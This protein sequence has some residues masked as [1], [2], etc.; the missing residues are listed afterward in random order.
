MRFL[1]QSLYATTS[2]PHPL[3]RVSVLIGVDTSDVFWQQNRAA[4]EA[5]ART[6][7]ALDLQVVSYPPARGDFLAFNALMQDAFKRNADY[8]VRVN[9]DTEFKT[10]GWIPLGVA[11]LLAFQ[12]PNVGVVGPTCH[13]GNTVILTHDMVHRTHLHIFDKYYPAVFHN[14]Y[15]D[16]WISTVYGPARTTKLS[17][18]VVHHHVELGTRYTPAQLDSRVLGSAVAAGVATIQA[19]VQHGAAQKMQI[20]VLGKDRAASLRRLLVSLEETDYA[21]DAVDVHIHIDHSSANAES[22]AVARAFVFSWGNVTCSVSSSARGLRGAWVQ[23]W[24]PAVGERAVI[25]EDDIQLSP[26]W[27]VWLKEAW[28]SYGHRPDLAG[29]SLQRQ[30]LVPQTPH[31]QREVVNEHVPFLYALV[32]SIGFSP[33]WRHWRAFVT[34]MASVDAETVNVQTPGLVTSEWFDRLDRRQV[35]TQY[36]IWYCREHGLYTLYVNLPDRKTL[37]AHMREKGQHYSGHDGRDFDVATGVRL[38]FPAQL[39]RY[40]W[41]GMPVLGRVPGKASMPR[42]RHVPETS[43]S[44]LREALATRV[45]RDITPVCRGM[46]APLSAGAFLFVMMA[47]R[48]FVPLIQN[49]ICNTGLMPGVHERTLIIFTDA[50]DED[51]AVSGF[52]GKVARVRTLPPEFESDMDY[53][54]YGYWRLVQLRVQLTLELVR[55]GVPF[56][57]CEPDALWVSNP[58]LDTALSSNED[59]I[60]FDDGGV[61]GFGWVRVMPT[62]SVRAIFTELER[63]FSARMQLGAGLAAH[64]PMQ[65]SDCEQGILRELVQHAT[66]TSNGTFGFKMLSAT[67]YVNGMWYDGGRGG[68]GVQKRAACRA[69]GAGCVCMCA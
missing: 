56:L 53:D 62:G 37:A 23:A 27:Y 46:L 34:W 35:W 18:W 41:D 64:S 40:G 47:N 36:F 33:H 57:L 45:A 38:D 66:R 54:T 28:Q 5:T 32:G 44:M 67:K 29:I 30:T 1:V 43:A 14:W 49:W 11:Q 51:L 65:T 21:G 19:Y 52:A 13:Q 22:V 61:P 4:V 16:D 39:T 60:G 68:D 8:L 58:L 7:Y 17:A 25:L 63:L 12:P 15:I 69:D 6:R 48:A 55:A 50:G 20:H 31:R 2:M 10:A 42:D 59:I 26:R 24:D 9:D 3:Y